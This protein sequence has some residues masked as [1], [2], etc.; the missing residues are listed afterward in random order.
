MRIPIFQDSEIILKLYLYIYSHVS[1]NITL[2][3][4]RTLTTERE[5]DDDTDEEEELKRGMDSVKEAFDVMGYTLL[6]NT[7]AR[8][9]LFVFSPSLSLSF[10][11]TCTH[12][13]TR[14]L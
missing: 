11:H 12:A 4:H 13:C 7:G 5:Q 1:S 8:L 10:T 2:S 14:I 3:F 9:M 6:P